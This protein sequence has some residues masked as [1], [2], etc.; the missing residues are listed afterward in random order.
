MIS[1]FL[2]TGNLLRNAERSGTVSFR[3]FYWNRVR[4][5]VPAAT[6][7]LVFTYC[8]ATFLFL[9]F[10]SHQ[11]GV[12]ALYAFAF[13]ANWHFAI[14]G[15]DYFNATNT[16]SPIQH[17]WSLSIEEQFYFIW[18]AVIFLIS[19]LVTRR[20]WTHSHRMQLASV[21]LSVIVMGSLGWAIVQTQT[22]PTWAYFDTA[23][24]V[25]ELGVGAL[26]ATSVTILAR[27]PHA[28]RPAISWTGLALI[29][30]SLV[31]INEGSAGFPAPLA[32]FPVT[33]AALV[34]AAGIGGEPR[35]QAFLRNPLSGY[36]GDISYSLYLVHW[37][38][39]VLLGALIDG[40]AA[41]YIIVVTLAFA[42]SILS[43]HF[44]E[45][46]LRKA[47]WG[48]FRIAIHDLRKH[49]FEVRRS[50]AYA[51]AAALTLLVVASLAYTTRP[52][53][54][55]HTVPPPLP[56][57][58]ASDRSSAPEQPP[59]AAALQ[60]EI[61][62]ALRTAEWPALNPSMESVINGPPAA[63]EVYLRGEGAIP[64]AGSCTWGSATAPT[65]AVLV[66]N[67][68]GVNYSGPLREIALTSG[69]A[70]Q[71][72][73]EAKLG[74]YFGEATSEDGGEEVRAECTARK[75]HAVD[76]INETKPDV[77]IISNSYSY[78]TG[79]AAGGAALEL[80]PDEL[81]ESMRQMVQRIQNSTKKIVFVSAPPAG[82]D[83]REC[84]GKRA[85][86]PA[87]C[88]T[89]ISNV[90]DTVSRA[91]NDVAKAV[92]GIWIDSRPWFCNFQGRLCPSF[93]GSTPTKRDGMHMSPDYGHKI[94]PIIGESLRLAG[95]F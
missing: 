12:D 55:E 35:F 43:Y 19:V 6:L 10:R 81:V 62:D 91:E 84:Y 86:T 92:G 88:V 78:N 53:A 45:G 4:R 66:G 76:V 23:S 49:R 42:L 28:I 51:A 5:I 8:A 14:E 71:L 56:L 58:A 34:I 94:A 20:A 22:A 59:L 47:E 41:Y 93:V 74:C 50:S 60:I 1:G 48:R 87:D 11:V 16:V 52:G 24:R 89:R 15:T 38:V 90:W 17:Y 67:S 57:V 40:G 30:T 79:E 44:V 27:I 36:I 3:Q 33:G 2:I 63:A 39:I 73:S 68:I 70:L 31:I 9:P 77:V 29:A 69:G 61:L 7:I 75:Q 21:A 13:L 64:D 82:V 54:Y 25:W 18:P 26:L 32:L 72:H 80:T 95:V 83:V 85:S 46:P 37:P 65:H